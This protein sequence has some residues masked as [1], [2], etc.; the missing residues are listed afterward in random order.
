MA[1]SIEDLVHTTDRWMVKPNWVTKPNRDFTLNRDT[2]NKDGTRYTLYS[3]S[4]YLEH[5]W[6]Y[7]FLVPD[8]ETEFAILYF[9]SRR[10]GR[11]KRFW[12]PVWKNTFTLHTGITMFDG[13]CDVEDRRFANVYQGYERLFILLTN[14]NL[15]TRQIT[16]VTTPEDG[17][18]RFTVATVFDRDI[19]ITDIAYFGRF[20]LCRM[21]ADTLT[22]NH[23]TCH[24]STHALRLKELVREYTLAGSAES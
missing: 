20:M 18:E 8:K 5:S 2:L 12:T 11:H 3:I 22:M 17:V 13:Y 1:D 23:K 10:R 9:F 7:E 21:N 16:A 6:G 19:A 24:V 4:D 15:I 14:G